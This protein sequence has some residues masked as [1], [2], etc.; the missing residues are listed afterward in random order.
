MNVYKN[1]SSQTHKTQ[2]GKI[3]NFSIPLRNKIEHKSLPQ[4]DP[5][6]F[7]ECQAMLLN[8]DKILELEF[9]LDYC[10]RESLSFSLQLFP[11]LENLAAA[12]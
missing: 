7:A 4:I 11:S 10:I 8:F 5:D 2:F 1:I 9:G 6:L 12:V 3:W